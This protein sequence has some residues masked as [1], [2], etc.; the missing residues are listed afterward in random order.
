MKLLWLNLRY[1]KHEN[2]EDVDMKRRKHTLFYQLRNVPRVAKIIARKNLVT[3][4][5]IRFTKNFGVLTSNNEGCGSLNMCNKLIRNDPER[6]QQAYN[7][8]HIV[9]LIC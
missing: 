2:D 9:E 3:K 7:H 1:K 8:V 6:R 5:G 4:L